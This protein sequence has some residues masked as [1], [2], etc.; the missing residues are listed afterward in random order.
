MLALEGHLERLVATENGYGAYAQQ[1]WGALTAAHGDRGGAIKFQ[2]RVVK[3]L[4]AQQR[5][6]DQ[7]KA[8]CHLGHLFLDSRGPTGPP[9][10]KKRCTCS[11]TASTCMVQNAHRREARQHF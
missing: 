4:G 9:P 8:M 10:T 11:Y 5:F 2:E 6:R 1:V 7:G 3:N